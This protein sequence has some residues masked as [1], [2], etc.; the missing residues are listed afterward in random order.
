MWHKQL[1][2]NKVTVSARIAFSLLNETSSIHYIGPSA[3]SR[4]VMYMNAAFIFWI[5]KWVQ[6][7]DMLDP[8]LKLGPY[9]KTTHDN[10]QFTTNRKRQWRIR[11]GKTGPVT[12]LVGF[13][14]GQLSSPDGSTSSTLQWQIYSHV[15]MN[16]QSVVQS[17][18]GMQNYCGSS[19]NKYE[20]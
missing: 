14:W 9:V 4:W 8:R 6:Q 1:Y 11:L 15:S 20:E 2:S 12:M 3:L 10:P 16:V 5:I 7:S 17:A 18:G 13:E 19:D